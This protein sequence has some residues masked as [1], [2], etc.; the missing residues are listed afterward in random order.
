MVVCLLLTIQMPSLLVGVEVVQLF[1]SIWNGLLWLIE[2]YL[3]IL[4]Y[5][6]LLGAILGTLAGLWS[7]VSKD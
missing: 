2:G 5:A 7:V 4:L 6:A 3:M 1:N